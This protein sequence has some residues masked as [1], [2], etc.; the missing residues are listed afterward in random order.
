MQVLSFYCPKCKKT[1]GVINAKEFTI[2]ICSSCGME[3]K[4]AIPDK[5]SFKDNMIKKVIT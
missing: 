4:R 3:M 5:G 1:E 2:V